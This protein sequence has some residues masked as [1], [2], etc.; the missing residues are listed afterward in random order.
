M[1]LNIFLTGIYILIAFSVT[2]QTTSQD[3]LITYYHK[4]PAKALQAADELYKQSVKDNNTPL[5]IKSLIL[6]TSFN[7]AIDKDRLQNLITDLEKRV[8]SEKNIAARSILHSYIGEL[9]NDY[10]KQNRYRISQRTPLEGYVPK[11]INEWSGNLFREKIYQHYLA[12]IEAKA[13]LQQTPVETYDPIL[14]MGKASDSLRPTLY[15]FLCFRTIEALPQIP[16]MQSGNVPSPL[17]NSSAMLSGLEEFLAAEIPVSP[18]DAVS[19]VLKTYQDLLAFRVKAGN[20]AALL[21][22]DLSRIDYAKNIAAFENKNSLYFSTLETMAKTYASFPIVVEVLNKQVQAL[23]FDAQVTFRNTEEKAVANNQKALAICEA[24]IKKYP[25]YNRI[26]ILRQ[27]LKQITAPKITV[28]YPRTVYPGQKSEIKIK[29]ENIGKI[30]LSIIQ[31]DKST[32]NYLLTNQNKKKQTTGKT[33]FKHSYK[34]PGNLNPSDT[35]ISLPRLESGLY[36]VIVNAPGLEKPSLEYFICNRLFTTYQNTPQGLKFFVRDLM[37]GQPVEKAKI[38]L[39]KDTYS[40]RYQLYDSIY[41]DKEGFA[42]TILEENSIYYETVNGN[43]PN[44]YMD[45]L[46][47]YSNR[48]RISQADQQHIEIITDRKIYRPG[49]TVYFKGIVWTATSDTMYVSPQQQYEVT[50]KD[51]KG[52]YISGK[53]FTTNSFGSFTGEFSIP[54]Q[55]LNGEFSL[56]TP[57]G[58]TYFTVTDYKRPEF[59]IT[60]SPSEKRYYFGDQ[61]EISGKVNSFSGVSLSNQ[62]VKYKISRHS[63]FRWS[64]QNSITQGST[65]TDA[66]GE[67]NFHF[68]AELPASINP[69]IDNYYYQIEATVTDAKGETQ[70]ASTVIRVFSKGTAPSIDMPRLI[71]KNIP[72]AFHLSIPETTPTQIKYTIAKL[73]PPK[74]LSLGLELKDTLVD[75]IIFKGDLE[76]QG[77][78]S[79]KPDLSS[80]ES[81]AYLLTVKNGNATSKSIFFLY[82]ASDKR[83]P[84]PTY[85]WL[86]REKTLCYPGESA[87]ILLGTSVENAYVLCEL[88]TTEGLV[89]QF[90][91]KLSNEVVPLEIPFLKSYGSQAWLTINYIKNGHY[92]QNTVSLKRRKLQDQKLTLITKVFRDKLTPGQQESWEIQVKNP[93]G[94]K[95]TEVLAMMYDASLD[96][97][98]PYQ[99]NF[100]PQY[101]QF[102]FPYSWQYGNDLSATTMQRIQPWMFRSVKFSIPYFQYDRLNTYDYSFVSQNMLE[103]KLA[104]SDQVFTTGG[105]RIRGTNSAMAQKE[106]QAPE[107]M[108]MQETAEDAGEG[109]IEDTTVPYRQNFAETAFF[110]PQ[111][112][113]DTDGIVKIN[114]TMPEST[115]RW[116]FMAL[117]YTRQLAHGKLTEYITTSREL[118]VRPNMPRFLRSGD[119]AELKVTVSNLSQV[120]QTGKVTLELFTPQNEKIIVSRK[121]DFN[122]SAGT[123]QTIG[124]TFDVP[125][126]IDL[127]GCRIAAVSGTYSDGEQQLLPVLPDRILVTSTQPIY[128]THAGTHSFTLKPENTKREDYRLT[129]ELTANPVWYA[130]MALPPLLDPQGE[131]VTDIAGAFY[132][133]TL[134]SRIARSNPEIANTIQVWA[135]KQRTSTTLLSKLEQNSELKNILLEASPWVM[136]AQNETERIQSLQQVFDQNRVTYLRTQA[137]QKL[138]DLQTP[139]GGWSWFKGMQPSRFITCNVL[140]IMSQASLA[141]EISYQEAEKRM[142]IRALGYLDN[143]IQKDFAKKPEKIGYNQLVYLYTRSTYR[144]IPLGDALEAHKYF[145]AL[146]KKQWAGLSLY[147]KALAA[148]TLFRYGMSVE[149]REILNSIREYAVV[150]P[151]EGMYWPE[152]RNTFYRN[153]TVL[154]Q[155]AII[156]AFY[157]MSKEQAEITPMKQW[158]LNQKQTQSWES[159]PATV[160][161]I[162]ALL[163]TGSDRLSTP[164]NLDVRLGK[165]AI[166]VPAT[167]DPLGYIKETI[168]AGEIKKDMLTVKITKTTDNP[169][170]GG[171]YLQY[172]APLS[173]IKKEA[174]PLIGIEKKLFVERKTSQGTPAIVPIEQQSVKVGDKLIVRL[175]L[176][177]DR[178][179]EF[180][181][182]KDLRA[183]CLEPQKQISGLRWKFGTVYYEDVKDAA[184]NLFFTALARGTY[185]IEYPVW[186][187]QVGEYQDG[188]ATFQS[189]YAP[190]FNAHSD[191]FRIKVEN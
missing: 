159:V 19:H 156:E 47:F 147:E 90:Y 38:R 171:L 56:S 69:M 84:I 179:M 99:I 112:Q 169:S 141:G 48:N 18:L 183:A 50:F 93:A 32:A 36:Q 161:A 101:R 60:F 57:D 121:A 149:A 105:I 7:L 30:T 67:F 27:Q 139:S 65:Y 116:K 95:P 75:K 80:Y 91:Q 25:H 175:T 20:R 172:F 113:T 1:K 110:Y 190:E 26:D 66:A 126:G 88:Y 115:T 5:L 55:T 143:E 118:M 157:E 22:A 24:G 92:I 40:G 45:Y 119:K 43:N 152:N 178:D 74:E 52:N 53:K 153:S 16:S 117:A 94:N 17:R 133:N 9:Y 73:F 185:V 173:E 87:R 138:N 144:D 129:L 102:S 135:E 70:Q 3:S 12:S 123:D 188:I 151:T 98:Q 158:L 41:T 154:T 187:N 148:Q 162:H 72:V 155:T 58:T 44:G 71:N 167:S 146:V 181:H 13:I 104:V 186:V 51:A 108:E 150:S 28:E 189:V 191:A 145:M 62:V 39:C 46:G 107:A 180:L 63:F 68:L 42:T 34:L 10:Y 142:Q 176:R 35:A 122:L 182:L 163:L 103:S 160:N 6:K 14:I 8:E 97:L 37:S 109:G 132:V 89:K 21:M 76:I 166:A 184:T 11:Q 81:G 59:E 82:S 4:Y 174:Q 164:E 127:A 168:P 134:A 177:L 61:I 114:F 125:Q 29:S 96:K 33:I 79:L 2:G 31:T 111:L 23:R 54:E 77:Q 15:D 136:Q 85:D 131:S 140:T 64:G 165:K 78:D 100:H 137:L 49:Q 120:Q 124:F 170:W 130:V 128:S 86:I 83:P 106:S